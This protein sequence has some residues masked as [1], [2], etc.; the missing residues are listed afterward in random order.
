MTNTFNVNGMQGILPTDVITLYTDSTGVNALGSE[1]STT[2]YYM[3]GMLHALNLVS[4]IGS[5]IANL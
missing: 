1:S 5:G 4:P 3:Y 2:Y